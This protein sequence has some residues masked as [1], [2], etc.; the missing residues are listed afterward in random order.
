[1]HVP[2]SPTLRGHRRPVIATRPCERPGC[3][4]TFSVTAGTRRQRYCSRRCAVMSRPA[5][6]GPYRT[7]H[8]SE[9]RRRPD[10][11]RWQPMVLRPSA[12]YYEAGRRAGARGWDLGACPALTAQSP[13]AV[14]WRRGYDETR[15]TPE[16]EP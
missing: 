11:P 3:D 6:R 8:V 1:M 10:A 15:T 5:R 16:A 12:D 13:D 2:L 14:A 9:P 7:E 4:H